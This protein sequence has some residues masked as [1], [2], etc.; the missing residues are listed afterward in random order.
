MEVTVPVECSDQSDRKTAE[1]HGGWEVYG[2]IESFNGLLRDEIEIVRL[3]DKE[4][5]GIH[6]NG[7]TILGTTNK[8]HFIFRYLLL[9]GP[10]LPR[11]ALTM[12][13]DWRS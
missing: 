1:H 7:G 5:A 11:I 2:S 3:T 12:K 6:V 9:M 10:G 8:V 13:K 4:I